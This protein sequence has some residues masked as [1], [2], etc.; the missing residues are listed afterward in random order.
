VSSPDER[1]FDGAVWLEPQV[2]IVS[3]RRIWCQ[4]GRVGGKRQKIP[5]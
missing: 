1:R 2:E 3:R 4:T 5:V